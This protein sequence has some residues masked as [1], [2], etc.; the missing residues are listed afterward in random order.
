M[1]V[2]LKG[3]LLVT[4]LLLLAFSAEPLF[5]FATNR[6]QVAVACDA[7]AQSPPRALWI[8]V[9]GCEMDY[10][11]A[12]FREQNGRIVELYFPARP[13]D[14]PR[15]QPAPIVATTR[16]PEVL[17]L[18]EGT[19]GGGRTPDQ[20]QFLVM[21]LK[22]VTALRAAR[23]IEGYGQDNVG[24]RLKS[25]ADLAAL[26][27]P[28]APD[29]AVIELHARPRLLL[30]GAAAAAGVLLLGMVA[31]LRAKRRG[32]IKVASATDAA[33]GQ[34]VAASEPQHAGHTAPPLRVMLLNLPRE[35]GADAIEHAPPLG[36]REDV[37]SAL[38]NAL[39]DLRF[40]GSRTAALE[41]PDAQVTIDIGTTDPVYTAVVHGR[42]DALPVLRRI[43]HRTGWRAFDAR[44]GAF[45]P[46]DA[47]ESAGASLDHTAA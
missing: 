35:A 4:G 22:I 20:E 42:G 9:T 38:T 45:V 46:A 37:I 41:H 40:D 19:M 33:D 29:A 6:Q 3:A 1:R 32:A 17:T 14:W 36:I 25:R 15:T 28:L 27:T 2:M 16:D 23:E 31:V 21:M 30:P 43:L 26:S 34:A 5:H 47:V 8:R 12:G 10:L 13:I 39:E 24:A 7:F 44:S 18:A 11:G